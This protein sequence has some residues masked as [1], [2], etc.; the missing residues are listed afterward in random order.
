[1][2]NLDLTQ[3]SDMSSFNTTK[4]E[5]PVDTTSA[6]F[7]M[8]HYII[9]IAGIVTNVWFLWKILQTSLFR[10]WYSTRLV[11]SDLKIWIATLPWLNIFCNLSG[12]II[13][14]LLHINVNMSFGVCIFI[15]L[16]SRFLNFTQMIGVFYI[17]RT[18]FIIARGDKLK[19]NRFQISLELTVIFL[20]YTVALV[21][22]ALF[23]QQNN[24]F[25]SLEL[26]PQVIEG[27]FWL[28][29]TLIILLMTLLLV[30]IKKRLSTNFPNAELIQLSCDI[31]ILYS[32]FWV[33][34]TVL[35][36]IDKIL[37]ISAALS[38]P[39]FV[40]N[41]AYSWVKLGDVVYPFMCLRQKYKLFS[42]NQNTVEDATLE[43]ISDRNF[44]TS[45]T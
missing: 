8:I 23:F 16:L 38:I 3:E 33:P 28:L 11:T 30:C 31:G 35:F 17:L 21:F 44:S 32:F 19:T 45:T 18:A 43:M 15:S 6:A 29:L 39:L 5:A 10:K 14:L 42:N 25:C 12:F 40:H 7:F 37:V 26:V 2:D 41:V 34:P 13:K 24:I 22:M 20:V 9:L 36:F 27:G 1:M 4:Q